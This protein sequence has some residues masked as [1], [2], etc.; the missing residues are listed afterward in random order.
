M[1][2]ASRFILMAAMGLVCLWAQKSGAPSGGTA[3][4]TSGGTSGGTTTTG[5]GTGSGTGT[6]PAQPSNPP[7][8]NPAPTNQTPVPPPPRPVFLEGTVIVDDGSPLPANV[9]IQSVCGSTRQRTVAHTSATGNFGF[10]WGN[11]G[12]VF[13]DASESGHSQGSNSDAGN[14]SGSAGGSGFHTTDPLTDCDLQADAPGYTSSKVSLYQHAALDN[15]DVGAIKCC[16]ASPAT[17][18]EW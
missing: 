10:L 16:T 17:K 14:A 11:T 13:Q 6:S 3:G 4:G 2:L 7:M 12:G 5:T 8:T 15:F 1:K 18:D 9:N